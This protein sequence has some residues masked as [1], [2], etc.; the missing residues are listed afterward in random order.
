MKLDEIQ[1]RAD[2]ATP[3]PW[4]WTKPEPDA[5][6][7]PDLYSQADD[8]AFMFGASGGINVPSED[9]AFIAHARTDVPV[10]LA[11]IQERD[12][13]LRELVTSPNCGLS[14]NWEDNPYCIYCAATGKYVSGVTHEPTC[15]I[16]R[17]RALLEL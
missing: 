15:P 2:A 4:A 10:L 16:A 6:D 1:A 17:A 3:G 7:G 12:A 8:T 14:I 9:A 13:L 11:A 5:W